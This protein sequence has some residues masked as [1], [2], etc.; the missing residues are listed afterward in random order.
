MDGIELPVETGNE[1]VKL[2]RALGAH[3]YVASRAHDIHAFVYEAARAAGEDALT[4]RG[5]LDDGLAWAKRTI[6]SGKSG[7]LDL[8][9]KDP[10]LLRRAPDDE[11][12]RLLGLFWDHENAPRVR[13]AL[14]ERLRSID[15]T[16]H[17]GLPFD[18][19][20]EADV[21]P[22][23]VDAGW[24]LLPLRQLDEERHRGVIE[25]YGERV[26]FE[27]ARFDEENA[28]PERTYLY[29]LPALGDAELLHAVDEQGNLRAPL[30]LWAECEETYLDYLLRGITRSATKK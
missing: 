9:S 29:E 10:R 17:E 19:S 24:E 28:V 20:R 21:F 18:E 7:I 22:L 6:D 2:V 3:R 15:A 11:L 12:V 1:A 5:G 4:A 25:A 23:L 27:G 13:D 8:G 16:V 30:V 14:A 26:F